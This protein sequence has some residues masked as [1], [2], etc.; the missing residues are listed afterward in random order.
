MDKQYP[1]GNFDYDAVVSD[2]QLKK[3]IE[4]IKSLPKRIENELYYAESDQL[5]TPYREG[6]WTVKQVV[7]HLGDSHMNALIRFKLTLTEDNPTIKP[8]DEM[9]W[10]GLADY[11][12]V[13]IQDSLEFI[14]IIHAK[15]GAILDDMYDAD[16]E[17]TFI[18]PEG[19]YP[20]TLRGA[21]AL[22]AWHGNH[23]LAHIQLVTK[24][25]N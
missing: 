23:H 8:Y 9:A 24:P 6:G 19:G 2:E 21:T 11:V 12:K 17:R 20:A 14:K 18:H 7:H 15:W 1:I 22:Y 16:F 5:N 10:S 25:N 13:P 4:E 3:A